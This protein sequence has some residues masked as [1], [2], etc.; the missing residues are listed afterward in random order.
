[1]SA[2]THPARLPWFAAGTLPPAEAAVIEGHLERCADC[3]AEVEALRSMTRTLRAFAPTS[4]LTTELLVAYHADPDSLSPKERAR[5]EDHLRSCPACRADL[6]ALERADSTLRTA[7]RRRLLGA[8]ASLLVVALTGWQIASW[9]AP[10]APVQDLAHVKLEPGQRGTPP[11]VPAGPCVLEVLLPV[12]AE[13]GT[14]RARVRLPGG[15]ER[16]LATSA[17]H[18]QT[19]SLP[20]REG[21]TP[22]YHVLFLTPESGDVAD[23]HAYGFQ[24]EASP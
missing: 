13:E 6:R 12:R 23:A 14:Y 18:A 10:G 3:R 11:Q 15:E 7:G 17:S 16:A 19:L 2:H 21:F 22:G 9:R 8:A 20:V 1:M 24:V 4:H 5:V